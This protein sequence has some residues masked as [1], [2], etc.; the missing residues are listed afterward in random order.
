M[1]AVGGCV[2]ESVSRILFL[3]SA[4]VWLVIGL[5]TPVMS[6]SA[7]GKRTL[8]GS[9]STDTA[10]Y[11]SPPEELL[12]SNPQLATLRHVTLRAVAGLL[13][14]AGLLTAGIAWFGLRGGDTWALGLLTVAGLAVIPYWWIVFG[15][16]RQA[17]IKLGLLDLPP[18]MWVPGVLMPVASI[19]G[20]F[21]YLRG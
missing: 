3:I 6:D 2:M 17:G 4:G 15:P 1:R 18:F 9:P 20:W 16:Y 12:A 13:V 7:I 21:A 19:L 8:F 5:L 11:G 14:A 10:L